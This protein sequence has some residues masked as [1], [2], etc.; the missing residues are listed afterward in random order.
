MNK[1]SV[2]EISQSSSFIALLHNRRL[3]S[4]EELFAA[5]EKI[6]LLLSI[7]NFPL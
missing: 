3:D 6:V 5:M 4:T 2:D 1:G 7:A